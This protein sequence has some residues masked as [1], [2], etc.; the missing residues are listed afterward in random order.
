[1]HGLVVNHAFC[2]RI[3]H[4]RTPEES[5][6]KMQ[7]HMKKAKNIIIHTLLKGVQGKRKSIL[8]NDIEK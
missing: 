6:L 8:F 3:E 7:A 1:M 4:T 5:S 2:T